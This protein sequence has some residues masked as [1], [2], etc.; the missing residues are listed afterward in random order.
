[1]GLGQHRIWAE[2]GDF[3]ANLYIICKLLLCLQHGHLWTQ[4]QPNSRISFSNN[5]ARNLSY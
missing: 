2:I 3:K 4:M 5:C 1:M